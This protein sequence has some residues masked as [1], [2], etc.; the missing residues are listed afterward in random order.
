MDLT[1]RPRIAGDDARIVEIYNLQ[2]SDSEPLTLARYRAEH[3]EKIGDRQGEEWV[4]VDRDQMVAVGSFAQAWWTGNPGS[5]SVD[6]RVDRSRWREGIGTALYD[7]LQ[8]R[9][10]ALEATRLLGW[11]RVDAAADRHFAFRRGFDETDQVIEEYRLHI[12]EANTGEYAGL[13]ER[14]G[15]EG[16]RIAPLKEL[17]TEDEMFLRVLQHL[18]ADSGDDPP[19]P[20]R[21]R[22]S[23]PSWQSQVLHAPG[24]SPET[25]WVALE[26]ERPVGMT[27]L[28]RLSGD[29]AENDYTGVASTHRGR[30]IATALKLRA[31]AWARERGVN[32]FYTSSEIGNSPMLTINRRLGYRPGVRRVGVARD[33]P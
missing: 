8:S 14:L 1:L 27:F 22:D 17:R 9:L 6:L 3:A 12:P 29:A 19:D 16:L 5:Y 28:K 21:L 18:W 26:G 25:H 20:E 30:G 15:R 7:P 13:E 32:W 10:V 4:A 31:I 2:E 23:F 33:A 24:L 11:L